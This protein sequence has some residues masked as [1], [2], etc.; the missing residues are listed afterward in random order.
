MGIYSFLAFKDFTILRV[1]ESFPTA[2]DLMFVK[3]RK[4][5]LWQLRG[6]NEHVML[7]GVGALCGGSTEQVITLQTYSGGTWFETWP[8]HQLTWMRLIEVFLRSCRKTSGRYFK[9]TIS[10]P[11]H[12]SLVILMFEADYSEML[13]A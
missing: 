7:S 5:Y 3:R 8:G 13:A 1:P 12:Y 4:Q 2:S 9:Y 6:R 10:F 11:T